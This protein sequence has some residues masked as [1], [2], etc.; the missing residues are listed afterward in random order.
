MLNIF[1]QLAKDINGYNVSELYAELSA[2]AIENFP[3]IRLYPFDEMIRY[4]KNNWL[5]R[6]SRDNLIRDLTMLKKI[7]ELKDQSEAQVTKIGDAI[8]LS[9][10]DDVIDY[11]V[12]TSTN[13]QLK[14]L[15]NPISQSA[16][17]KLNESYKRIRIQ[18]SNA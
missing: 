17:I 3:D 1:N 8:I 14:R 4:A 9:A 11:I 7:A 18:R 2:E 10:H 15:F 12:K 16:K 5:N 6:I 13:E